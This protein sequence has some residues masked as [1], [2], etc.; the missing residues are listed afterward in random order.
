V[1]IRPEVGQRGAAVGEPAPAFALKGA[2]GVSAG[3]SAVSRSAMV[4]HPHIKARQSLPRR[5]IFGRDINEKL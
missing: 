5:S 1:A 2:P 4:S 3:K